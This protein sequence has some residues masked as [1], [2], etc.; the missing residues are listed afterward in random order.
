MYHTSFKRLLR[1]VRDFLYD[2]F[3]VIDDE[4]QNIY[5]FYVPNLRCLA[6]FYYIL[7]SLLQLLNV[8]KFKVIFIQKVVNCVKKIYY[9][10]LMPK[11]NWK[12]YKLLLHLRWMNHI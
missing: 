12:I 7:K 11:L 5:I 1:T 9:F 6:L 2:F 3:N 4:I 8:L 10:I